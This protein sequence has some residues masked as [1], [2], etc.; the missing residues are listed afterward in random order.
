MAEPL[1]F[2]VKD[3]SLHTF[4]GIDKGS[5]NDIRRSISPYH[6]MGDE[7]VLTKRPELPEGTQVVFEL[8]DR[9]E[10]SRKELINVYTYDVTPYDDVSVKLVLQNFKIVAL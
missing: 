5:D 1:K 8:S 2:N 4:F 10:I 6:M 9:S 7:I 3:K